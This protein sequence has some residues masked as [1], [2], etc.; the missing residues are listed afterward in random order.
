[1]KNF[2]N[3]TFTVINKLHIVEIIK[4]PDKYIIYMNYN[5]FSGFIFYGSGFVSSDYSKIE[6]C[7]IENNAD[8]N[9]ITNFITYLQ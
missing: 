2:I 8:Y 9:T 3:L 6:I 5:R 4:K 7:N 1:M